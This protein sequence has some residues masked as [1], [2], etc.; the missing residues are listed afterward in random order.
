MGESEKEG[1][2][3]EEGEGREGRGGREGGREGRR[4]GGERQITSAPTSAGGVGRGGLNEKFNEIT[5]KKQ[6]H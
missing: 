4:G 5:G 6:Q 1:N 2:G 3:V